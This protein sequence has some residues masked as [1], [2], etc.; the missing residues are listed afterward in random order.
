[1]FTSP[2][3]VSIRER[4]RINGVPVSKKVF[5]RIYW[6]VRRKLERGARDASSDHGEDGDL[7]PLP[8]Y[9]RM[10][11]LMAVYAFCHY[12]NPSIDVML[13]EVGVG[14]RYDATNV[15]EP[16]AL[17]ASSSSTSLQETPSPSV[18]HERLLVLRL[19]PGG[20]TDEKLAGSSSSTAATSAI[21]SSCSSA[22]TI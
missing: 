1:M 17:C 4:I 14:G 9:F 15:F 6:R 5:G 11:T 10:L 21:P 13:L 20:T 16:H 12:Q 2:H 8:G 3:L 18:L 19:L 7:P 22:F